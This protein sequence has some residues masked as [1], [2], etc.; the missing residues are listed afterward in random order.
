[1]KIWMPVNFE[2]SKEPNIQAYIFSCNLHLYHLRAILSA[3]IIKSKWEIFLAKL[4]N[5]KDFSEVNVDRL[6]N[7][8]YQYINSLVCEFDKQQSRCYF[9][10]PPTVRCKGTDIDLN[11]V[12]KLAEFGNDTIPPMNWIRHSCLKFK[13]YIYQT[14]NI[15]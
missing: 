10:V 6:K 1:M 9:Y 12:I 15:S 13:D 14:Y 2:T 4:Q 11:K 8:Q 7:A 5:I 3:N